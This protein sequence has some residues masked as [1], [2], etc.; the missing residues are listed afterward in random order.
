MSAN[1]SANQPAADLPAA[2]PAWTQ[3][4]VIVGGTLGFLAAGTLALWAH[5][6][7]VVFYE[8]M[9]AGLAACL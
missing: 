3:P 8:M 4:L 6:G 1:T 2:A 9:L 5:F 7:T